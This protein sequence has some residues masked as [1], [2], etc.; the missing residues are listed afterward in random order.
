MDMCHHESVCQ[1]DDL[2]TFL[3]QK[4]YFKKD[5]SFNVIS[6]TIQEN[7]VSSTGRIST[8]KSN[9]DSV[10]TASKSSLTFVFGVPL[11]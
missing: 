8:R 3:E 4:K 10:F 1:N 9:V 2:P 11:S 7:R 6:S 5:G